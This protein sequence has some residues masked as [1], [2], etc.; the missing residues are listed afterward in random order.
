MK[1]EIDYLITFL[2]S[3][4][5]SAGMPTHPNILTT[6]PDLASQARVSFE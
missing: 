5:I 4:L 2:I 6:A 1:M 3:I